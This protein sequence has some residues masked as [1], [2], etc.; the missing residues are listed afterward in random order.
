MNNLKTHLK[1]LQQRLVEKLNR[2]PSTGKHRAIVVGAFSFHDWWATFGDTEAMQVVAEWLTDAGISYDLACDM[3]NGTAGVD[4]HSINPQDYTIFIYVCGPWNDAKGSSFISRFNHCVKI[5]VNLTV[6]NEH[7]HGFDA[8]YPRD[9]N[10]LCNPDLAFARNT[11]VSST[12]VGVCLVHPQ[13]EYGDRQRHGLVMEGVNNFFNG[14]NA[15]QIAIDTLW[16]NNPTSTRSIQ[17]FESL[18]SRVDYVISSRLHGLVLSLRSGVP[19][20]AIDPIQG[21][22]KVTAQAKA[23]NWPFLIAAED[24]SAQAIAEMSSRCLDGSIKADIENSQ[25]L[26]AEYVQRTR[27]AFI[28]YVKGYRQD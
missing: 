8:L 18:I 9:L 4:L 1:S 28:N 7:S 11:T 15:V 13:E 22:G 14:G 25:R 24:V 20:I 6:L 23:I 17:Q 19:V 12:V 21:G 16:V 2:L 27:T 10:D 26:A 3:T 5:G